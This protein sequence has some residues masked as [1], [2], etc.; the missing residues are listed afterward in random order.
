MSAKNK[1]D[2]YNYDYIVNGQ[3]YKRKQVIDMILDQLDRENM[4]I[5]EISKATGISEKY[6]SNL[7]QVLRDQDLIMNTKL[8]RDGHYLYKSH[9]DCLLAKMLYPSVQEVEK[10]FTVKNRIV[11]TV[12]DGTSKSSGSKQSITYSSSY[13]DS[14]NWE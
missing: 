12:H 2:N 1:Y 6:M 14:V 7:M 4:T 5:L 10:K 13:Y 9:N 3:K 11:R 8:R